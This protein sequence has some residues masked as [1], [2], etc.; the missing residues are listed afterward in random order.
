MKS[1]VEIVEANISKVL[2][3]NQN[4]WNIFAARENQIHGML[5]ILGDLVMKIDRKKADRKCGSIAADKGSENNIQNEP[6]TV[7]DTCNRMEDGEGNAVS[8][9]VSRNSY[10]NFEKSTT[11]FVVELKKKVIAEL[12]ESKQNSQSSKHNSQVRFKS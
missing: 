4:L 5:Q 8:V 3:E 6:L 10:V 9:S 1:R 12:E 11:D 7:D 2:E